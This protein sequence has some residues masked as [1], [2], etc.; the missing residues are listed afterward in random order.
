M[1]LIQPSDLPA[2]A[3][4]VSLPRATLLFKHNMA[5]GYSVVR[6]RDLRVLRAPYVAG[7]PGIYCG[8][9]VRGARKQG[10]FAMGDCPTLIVV[11]GWPE[12]SLAGDYGTP[13]V[14]DSGV[15][16]AKGRAG[17]CSDMWAHEA[18]AA[19]HKAGKVVF[20]AHDWLDVPQAA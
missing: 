12:V 3:P 8:Y 16:V 6:V 11:D 2:V 4:F 20:D 19:A 14:T 18:R 7:A 17:S 10:A 13:T 5:C 1:M 9:T 15:T